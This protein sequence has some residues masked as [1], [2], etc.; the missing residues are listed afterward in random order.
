MPDY[1]FL[2]PHADW[3][4]SVVKY[5]FEASLSECIEHIPHTHIVQS[6]FV[7]AWLHQGA[8]GD[9]VASRNTTDSLSAPDLDWVH[10][11]NTF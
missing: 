5:L 4:K 7:A 1:I 9:H 11:G 2:Y 10:I 6:V 3:K 8:L